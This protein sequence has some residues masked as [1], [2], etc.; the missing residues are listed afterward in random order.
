MFTGI[1]QAL[2][3]VAYVRTHEGVMRLGLPLGELAGGL[4]PGASVAINGTCLTVVVSGNNMTEFDIIEE[5]LR[6]T[7]LGRL[8]PGTLVNVERSY[9]VGDEVGG[10]IVSGHVTQTVGLVAVE[11]RE[12][13]RNLT[14]AGDSA[15]AKYI[16]HK[17]FVALDGASLTVAW[18]D[19]A[20]ATFGVCL[21]P[22]TIERTTLGRVVVGDR[23]NIEIDSQTRATVDTVERML[24]SDTWIERIRSRV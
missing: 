24:A 18:A 11:E 2:I 10:H 15:L 13:V 19:E 5:T 8:R 16:Q 4:Q 7:N 20:A 21:I 22:E 12:G 14:L 6:L 1:V 17:G 23:I 9:R 3:P